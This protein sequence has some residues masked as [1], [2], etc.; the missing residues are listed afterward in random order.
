MK[1]LALAL[2]LL[3][4]LTAAAH[5]RRAP[6]RV[7]AAGAHVDPAPRNVTDDLQD[8]ADSFARLGKWDQA[9]PLYDEARAQRRDDLDLLEGLVN[10][11]VHSAACAPRRLALIEEG[12]A[13][14]PRPGDLV[15]ALADELI[16]LGRP[17][18]L[19]AALGRYLATHPDDDDARALYIDAAEGAHRSDLALRA[20][21]AHVTRRPSELDKRVLYVELLRN[22]HRLGEADRELQALVRAFPQSMSVTALV[23]QLALERGDLLTARAALNR[24]R[25][26]A[27]GTHDGDDDER[28]RDL[29]R[30][31]AREHKER[32]RDFRADAAWL[33]AAE[34]LQREQDRAH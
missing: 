2:T 14:L 9:L 6:R 13:R 29:E 5:H 24:A 17:Q 1:R 15:D 31:L 34:D 21:A 18:E 12:M 22:E 20:L 30:D 10:A 28:L 4:P 19:V 7:P 26:L 23:G 8:I 27:A 25:A 32:Y 16:R 3:M 11:C 33:D